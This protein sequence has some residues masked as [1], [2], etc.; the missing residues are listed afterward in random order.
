MPMAREWACPDRRQVEAGDRRRGQHTPPS[1]AMRR[2]GSHPRAMSIVVTEADT[3]AAK[4]KLTSAERRARQADKLT[5]IR[6]RM[7]IWREMD[8]RGITTPA[9]IGEALGMP[10]AEATG[11]L[12]RHQ[13][14]EG[15][16]ARLEAAATRLMTTRR[17]RL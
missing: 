7:A 3:A 1:F 6:V 16:V 11:L 13:W 8:E 14:R 4:P 2:R 9:E 5:M 17:P 15:D 10:A 12:N